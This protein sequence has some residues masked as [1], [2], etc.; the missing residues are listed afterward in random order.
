MEGNKPVETLGLDHVGLTVKKL[1]ETASFF[2]EQP[3][4]KIIG[5]MPDCPAIVFS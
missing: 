5:E 4:W 3:G 1:K 2:V